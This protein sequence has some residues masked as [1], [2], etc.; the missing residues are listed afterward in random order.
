MATCKDCV[1]YE[2]CKRNGATVD[3]PVDDGVCLTFATPES[4]RPVGY[5]IHDV[6]N[7]Y[8]CSECLERETM[9]PKKKKPFCPNCGA[10]MKGENDG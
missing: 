5:W 4:L 1:H 9:S 7:L 3:F 10:R 2:L 8:A 6:N